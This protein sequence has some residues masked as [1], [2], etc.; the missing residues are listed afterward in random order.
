MTIQ[1]LLFGKQVAV[2]SAPGKDEYEIGKAFIVLTPD[3]VASTELGEEIMAKL[4]DGMLKEFQLPAEITF[5]DSLP[6]MA[7]GKIDLQKLKNM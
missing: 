7:S 5:L 3:T 6:V 4:R 1:K 2:V